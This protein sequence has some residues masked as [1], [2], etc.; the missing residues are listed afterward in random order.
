MQAFE[1]AAG[2]PINAAK[3]F[4]LFSFDTMG[5]L[6]FG[7]SFDRMEA[8]EM[9][10]YMKSLHRN[11][12]MIGAFF[13][14]PW[15]MHILKNIPIFNMQ[16]TS[17]IAYS[18]RLAEQRMSKVSEKLTIFSP[19]LDAY[20]AKVVK[21][22]QDRHDLYGD[23]DL[24]VIA[25]SD[26]IAA[27]LTS[28]CFLLTQHPDQIEKCRELIRLANQSQDAE[29]R[30]EYTIRA[31]N[32]IDAIIL[33][34]L[35]LHPVIASGLQRVTPPEGILINKTYIPGG[36]RVQTPSYV[37]FRDER[38]FVHPN[39][40]IPERHTTQ[41]ELIIDSTAFIPFHTGVYS[42]LGKQLA[43]KECHYVIREMI[44]RFDFSLAPGQTTK[45]FHRS[46]RDT[47]T[48]FIKDLNVLFRLRDTL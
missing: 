16:Y 25:G 18:K 31:N 12:L 24:I 1:N 22:D 21:T 11:T 29:R 19:I 38:Y 42:C 9:D 41:R 6:G 5:E 8:G 36:V 28:A 45:K 14:T 40:F 26:T 3:W 4:N 37:M 39:D 48:L 47:F 27:T 35:R 2:K 10:Y 7:R 23:A 34:T 15:I 20:N 46:K 13:Q 30:R 17:F 32:H 43:M 33:E 44:Q